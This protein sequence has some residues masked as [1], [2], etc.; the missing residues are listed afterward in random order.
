[1]VTC[2][3]PTVHALAL[4]MTVLTGGTALVQVS[5]GV[6]LHETRTGESLTIVAA[7]HGLEVGTLAADNGL[8][9][10]ARLKPGQTLRVDNRHIVPAG[11]ATGIVVNVPQRMLFAFRDGTLVAAFPAAVGRATW[12]TPLGEHAIAVKEIDPTWDVP[13]SIQR[14]MALEGREVLTKVPPGPANPLGNRWL[15]LTAPACGI[16]GTNQPASIYRFTTH[17]CIR[18]HPDDIDALFGLVDVG[19]PVHVIY[20]P[21]LVARL[22]DGEVL[23]EVHRDPYRRASDRLGDARRLLEAAG[24]PDLMFAPALEAIVGAQRGR[25]EPLR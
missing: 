4:A 19:M 22:P 8:A 2:P 5:G 1:M 3:G 16:H 6:R 10:D 23:V 9:P 11:P 15:G 25:A 7:R 24:R 13:A 21:V 14:E 12:K 20:E 18:L 17:G